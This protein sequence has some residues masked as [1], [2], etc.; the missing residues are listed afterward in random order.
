MPKIHFITPCSVDKN[1]GRAINEQVA[2][3]PDGD[4]AC[5]MDGDTLFLTPNWVRHVYDVVAKHGDRFGLM[6][7]MTNRLR[8][9]IQRVGEMDNNHDMMRHYGIAKEL[10]AA[11]W[12]EVEDITRKKFIAGMFM[13]F[14]KTV[15]HKAKFKER[16]VAFDDAFSLDVIAAGYKIG[17]MRGLYVYHFYRG[18]SDS[19]ER[20]KKHLRP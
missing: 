4:W 2:I 6:G 16:N 10:E 9:S 19:P 1:F 18:W 11:R 5:V 14:P 20:D 13:L 15:W 7:C 17:L 3:I 8:R 12:A